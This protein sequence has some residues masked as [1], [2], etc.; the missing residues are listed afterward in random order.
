MNKS[1]VRTGAGENSSNREI[2]ID[3]PKVRTGD[4]K[5]S[6]KHEIKY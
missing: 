2:N 1:Q 5:N 4:T 6:G 3:L